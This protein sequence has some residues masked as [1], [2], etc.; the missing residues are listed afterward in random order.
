M[1]CCSCQGH[2]HHEQID[3]QLFVTE[4]KYKFTYL[5][6]MFNVDMISKGK[7]YDYIDEFIENI[8]R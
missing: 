7:F 2:E 6:P 5:K 8:D 3:F 1:L 4:A